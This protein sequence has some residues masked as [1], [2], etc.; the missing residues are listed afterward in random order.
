MH[1]LKCSWKV[2]KIRK[3]DWLVCK[4]A[5]CF[6]WNFDFFDVLNLEVSFNQSEDSS[7]LELQWFKQQ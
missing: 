6:C 2:A 4:C 1:F 7:V 3:M 5:Y